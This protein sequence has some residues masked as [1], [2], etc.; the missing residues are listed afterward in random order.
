MQEGEKPQ[1]LEGT[2]VLH[3]HIVR[4]LGAG[5]M[6]VVYQALDTKLGRQVALKFLPPHVGFEVNLKR[7][8]IQEAKAASSLDHPNVATIYGIEELEDGRMF[9]SMAYYEGETLAHMV[10][11]GPLP[12]SLAVSYAMQVCQGLS[13][14]HSR[15]VVH[16]DIKPSNILVTT[17]GVVKI[18]DF[19]LAK[20]AGDATLTEAG[21]TVGTAAYMSPEQ[22]RGEEAGRQSDVWSLGVVLYEMIAGKLP[23]PG[24]N[25]HSMMYKALHDD[26][27]PLD[28]GVSP[29]LDRVLKRALA[30]DKAER[31]GSAEELLHDLKA[32]ASGIPLEAVTRT[33]T[34]PS[35]PPV[36]RISTFPRRRKWWAA[37][38]AVP[39]IA[40]AVFLLP[41]SGRWDRTTA[42]RVAVLPFRNIGNDPANAALCEGLEEMLSSRLA[43]LDAARDPMLVIPAGEVRRRN[44]SSASDAKRLLGATLVI[45]GTLM[46][47]GRGLQMTLNLVDAAKLLT[48][49]SA[50]LSDPAGDF[51][52]LEDGAIRRVAE[53]LAMRAGAGEPGN[54]SSTVP[55]AYESYLKGVGYMGRFDKP[56][57]LDNAIA[58]FTK[59][60][61]TDPRFAL[62]YAGLGESSRLKYRIGKD[63]RWLESAVDN[64]KRAIALNDQLAPAYVTL[65]RVH[66]A[67]GDT[68]LAIQEFDTALKTEPRNPDAMLGL[69]G[70]YEHAG[71]AREAEQLYR[72]GIDLRP[73][74][75]DGYSRLAAFYTRQGR[76]KDAESQYRLAIKYAPDNAILFGNFGVLLYNMQ[77]RAE[78]RRM[79]ENSIALTPT[80][81]SYSNLGT[82]ESEEGR[83]AEAALVFE[84]ALKLNDRDYHVWN[85][86]ATAYERS[87]GWDARARGTLERAAG[88]AEKERQAHP[89]NPSILADL[90]TYNAKLGRAEVAMERLR[91]A[92]ALAPDDVDV[93]FWVAEAYEEMGRRGD[94]LA[95]LDAAFKLG[96]APD[97]VAKDPE[98]R[99]LRKDARYSALIQNLAKRAS[100]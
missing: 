90:A 100:K 69:A 10:R 97:R 31:Y 19:G 42:R 35:A 27:E 33:I 30:K 11:E 82:L 15:G 70:A 95:E 37:A 67:G 58:E 44:V 17:Q 63:P 47:T 48:L 2:Q 26:P 65:G 39:L 64:S 43:G 45:D 56:E 34:L 57:S 6:G 46:K 20:T 72:K 16:R 89:N 40:A 23:F 85:N 53:L 14:A 5:G 93:L 66:D 13:E 22:A 41:T 18:L 77:N 98:F 51:A 7:R 76:Y 12:V 62:A 68:N 84:R 73:E 32:I 54:K 24:S 60:V 8:L 28:A 94:A 83:Y 4:Q 25:A 86:L 36:S 75:W 3:F 59:A 55:A 80:Y 99:A 71:R 96:L 49:R 91:Q 78:A 9:I 79:F 74:F 81:S 38:A 21:A 50:V 61:Q 87:S 92:K 52:V 88:L 29:D 1:R